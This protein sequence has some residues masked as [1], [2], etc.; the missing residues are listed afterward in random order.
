MELDMSIVPFQG[1]ARGKT[2]RLPPNAAQLISDQT[3]H[4]ACP[5]AIAGQTRQERIVTQEQCT[6]K[7]FSRTYKP[8]RNDNAKASF[9]FC[10]LEVLSSLLAETVLC[11]VKE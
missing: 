11:F 2:C 6:R 8:Q 4:S 3:P 9:S 1:R 7:V 5:V 10:L